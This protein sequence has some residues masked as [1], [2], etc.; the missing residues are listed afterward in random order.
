MK[1]AAVFASALAFTGL[2]M[3]AEDTFKLVASK[4]GSSINGKYLNVNDGFFYIG[5]ETNSTCGNVAPVFQGGNEGW[6]A[7]YADGTQNQQQVFVDISGAS[8]GLLAFTGPFVEMA[9]LDHVTDQFNRTADGKL[10]YAGAAWLACPQTTGEYMVYPEKAYS[11][12]VGK[13]KCTEFEVTTK[14]VRTPKIVCV[15]Q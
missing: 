9:N 3:A 2:G 7:F 11:K 8:D 5:K 13:D 12:P 10:E 14:K 1:T 6:L 15:Y 4:P